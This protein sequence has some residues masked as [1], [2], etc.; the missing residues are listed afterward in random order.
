MK[1][2]VG[3]GMRVLP[4]YENI[5][6]YV[7]APGVL[8]GDVKA[9]PHATGTVDAVLAEDILEH[10]PRNEWRDA[11]AEWVRVLKPDG[12]ITIQFPDMVI[13]AKELI[14]AGTDHVRWEHWNR[15]V[16][17]GQGDGIGPGVGMFHYTGFSYAYLRHHCETIGLA[18]ISHHFNEA[19]CTLV[20]RKT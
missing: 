4:G 20:M 7:S 14:A 1:I 6:K 15:K 9:L 3:C 16:F 12:I 19:N 17:G 18:Y 13:L 5:D 11:L 2:N 10:F 8:V